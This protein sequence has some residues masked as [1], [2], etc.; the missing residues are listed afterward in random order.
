[1]KR[2]LATLVLVLMHLGLGLGTV[3]SAQAQSYRVSV[4]TQSESFFLAPIFGCDQARLLTTDGSWASYTGPRYGARLALSLLGSG[5]GAI[6]FFLQ[7]VGGDLKSEL[8]ATESYERGENMGGMQVYIRDWLFVGAG[9]GQ[10]SSK[11]KQSIGDTAFNH[12]TYGAGMGLEFNVADSFSISLQRWIKAGAISKRLNSSLS[13][14][15]GLEAV[16]GCLGIRWSPP[17]TVFTTR[18]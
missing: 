6:D 14:N 17:V 16:E 11:V 7:Y 10:T 1:M 12:T 13:T 2:T 9:V 5:E 8:V 3:K 4:D 18:N 15:D